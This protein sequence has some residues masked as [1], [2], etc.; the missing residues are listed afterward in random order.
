MKSKGLLSLLAFSEKRRD[1]LLL[2]RKEPRTLQEIKNNLGVT[3]PE[4]IPHIK[5]LEKSYLIYRTDKHY[6]L[7][8]IGEMVTNSFEQFRRTL[9]IFEKDIVFWKDHRIDGIPYELRNR[10]NELGEYTIYESTPTDIFMPHDEYIKNLSKSKCLRGVSSVFH[11]DYPKIILSM[12]ERGIPVSIIL[13][14]EVLEKI[15]KYHKKELE[16]VFTF[17]NSEIMICDEK[18]EISFTVT[19]FFFIHEA[20]LKG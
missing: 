19:D 4:I 8:G 14:R 5:K 2:I 9:R 12:A 15:K 20:F 16:Q 7:T 13:T 17:K 18:I 1:I 11:P 6:F 3:S 10:L